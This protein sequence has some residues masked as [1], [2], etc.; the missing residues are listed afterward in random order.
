R[1]IRAASLVTILI[2][3]RLRSRRCVGYQ[4][5]LERI[6]GVVVSYKRGTF[7]CDRHDFTQVH[8]QLSAR[9]IAGT[10]FAR[11]ASPRFT[12]NIAELGGRLG[13]RRNLHVSAAALDSITSG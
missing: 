2:V 6:I 4:C 10:K 3:S 12:V 7:Y 11:E 13:L 5:R 1:P 9:Q 8:S